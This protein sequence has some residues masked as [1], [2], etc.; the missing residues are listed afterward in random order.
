M[1]SR[2]GRHDYS[3]TYRQQGLE[4]TQTPDN[5]DWLLWLERDDTLKNTMPPEVVSVLS[6]EQNLYCIEAG[7]P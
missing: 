1:P 3:I 4:R 5:Q 6:G 7:R 2:F